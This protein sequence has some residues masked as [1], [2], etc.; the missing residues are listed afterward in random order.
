MN[1]SVLAQTPVV[2]EIYGEKGSIVFDNWW[3]TPV[4]IHLVALDGKKVD[5]PMEFIGNGYNYEASAVVQYLEQ[6]KK[7]SD[8]MSWEDSL[9]LIDT[10][11]AIRKEIGL[12]YP[13]HD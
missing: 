8:L 11:D 2:A 10:L 12:V 5:I 9:L 4:P 3:F 7:Q 1:S 6:G 13:D